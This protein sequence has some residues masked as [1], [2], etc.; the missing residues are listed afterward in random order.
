[1]AD[2]RIERT[3]SHTLH[4][5][6]GIALVALVVIGL[7]LVLADGASGADAGGGGAREAGDAQEEDEVPRRLQQ[8]ALTLPAQ[9]VRAA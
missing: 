3:E 2:I 4:W 5:L 9:P 1:M 6:L 7:F 8:W